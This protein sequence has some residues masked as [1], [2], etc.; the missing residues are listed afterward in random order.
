M[1][2][3]QIYYHLQG[4]DPSS[5]QQYVELVD[6]FCT[7][8]LY[9]C[10]LCVYSPLKE[11]LLSVISDLQNIPNTQE[12]LRGKI[13]YQSVKNIESYQLVVAN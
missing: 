10:S 4:S 11:S 7:G 9:E 8:F 12:V 6:E 3:L 5:V 2:I 13:P 1:Y